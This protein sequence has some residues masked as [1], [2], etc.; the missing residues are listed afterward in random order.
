MAD[1]TASRLV[2]DRS[3]FFAETAYNGIPFRGFGSNPQLPQQP[4][5][6]HPNYHIMI[7]AL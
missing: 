4:L 1:S 5:P 2:I 6:I 3:D 7:W